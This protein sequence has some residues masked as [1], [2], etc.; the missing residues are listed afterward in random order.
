MSL[1]N[2]MPNFN[3]HCNCIKDDMN[4]KAVLDTVAIDNSFVVKPI[5]KPKTAVSRR[6]AQTET[7]MIDYS[8][9]ATKSFSTHQCCGEDEA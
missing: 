7:L 5:K 6:T 1:F 2:W 4:S 9:L 3:Y 8:L